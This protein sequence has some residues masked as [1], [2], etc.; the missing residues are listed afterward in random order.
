ML[1]DALGEANFAR[2]LKDYMRVFYQNAMAEERFLA[3]LKQ[4]L[5]AEM[6]NNDYEKFAAQHHIRDWLHGTDMPPNE[7]KFTS[8][9]LDSLYEQQRKVLKKEPVDT[10]V[11]DKWDV[12]TLV[13]FLSLLKGASQEQ[14]QVL[15]QQM[16]FSQSKLMSIKGEWAR[17]C[18][19]VKYLPAETC[20][21]IVEYVIKRNSRFEAGKVAAFLAESEEGKRL[22]RRILDEDKGRLFTLTR[23]ELEKAVGKTS[24]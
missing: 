23:G 9:L 7:P 20:T 21:M 8:T 16:N 19:K 14:V 22:I 5:A 11:M 10:T 24:S 15:D 1:R 6:G 3:F 13:N 2:F 17:L 12:T 4:W 18:A